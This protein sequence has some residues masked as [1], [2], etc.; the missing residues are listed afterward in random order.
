MMPSGSLSTP[1]PRYIELAT[2]LNYWQNGQWTA[3]KEKIEIAADG[4]SASATQGQHQAY[5]PSDIYQGAIGLVMPDGKVLQSQPIGLGYD[6]GSKAVMFAVLTN[7]TGQVLASGNQIIY[8]NAFTTCAVDLLYSYTLAG[9]E[10]DILIKEE[11]P[12]PESLGL[13][14][15]T[16]RLQ[17]YTEFFNA[18]QPAV[19]A[20]TLPEQAGIALADQTL[21]FGMM[22]MVP[23]RA[24]LIGN[25]LDSGTANAQ[26][27][28]Q[29]VQIGNRQILV[30][31][32]PVEAVAAALG[33]LPLPQITKINSSNSVRSQAAIKFR[34]PA[35][36]LAKFASKKPIMQASRSGHAMR[37]LLLDYQILNSSATN[38][39]FQGDSTYYISGSLILSGTNTFEGGA[40]LK[41]NTN[42]SLSVSAINWLA[43]PY[44][45]V[46]FTGKDDN[47]VG[48]TI[49]GS[50]GNPTNYYANPALSI[51][52]PGQTLTSFRIACARQGVSTP[53]SSSSFYNG[54]FV[55]CQ[56][57]LTASSATNLLRNILFANVKTNFNNLT[58]SRID[59][60]NGTFGNSFY[61]A[62]VNA[63]V[64]L[65]VTNSILASVTNLYSGSPV[66][67]TGGWNGFY[68]SPA[69]GGSQTTNTTFPFKTAGAGNYYLT[70]GC[71]FT[72]AGTAYIDAALWSGL[73]QKTT[74]SP[75][76]YSN[77][78]I[79][80]NTNFSPQAQRDTNSNPNLGY[81]YEPIDYLAD[82]CTITNAVLTVTNG[83][84][85]ASYNE[86]GVRLHNKSTIVSLGSPVNP[87]WFV[88]YSAVQE[89]PIS[90]K[91]SPGG[92][93]DVMP[94]YSSAMPSG[95]FRFTKFA[96][97]ANGGVHLYDFVGSS[98]SNLV[99]QD[100]E[101]WSGTNTLGGTNGAVITFKNNLFARSIIN[102]SGNGV[103]FFSNNLAWG[104]PAVSL[105]RTGT[106]AWYVFNNSF[107]S[108]SLTTTNLTNGNNAFLNCSGRI[109]PTNAN[110]V[111]SAAKL[112]YQAGPLGIFYQ[113][114]GSVLI[115]AGNTNADKIGFYHY[116]TQ[117]NQVKESNSIIDIGYHY[118]AAGANGLPLDSNG[119]GV[120]DY[121][122]DAN[123]NGIVD[124][125]EINW[126]LAIQI[127]PTNQTM[128][129][130]SNAT[131]VVTA[132]GVAP[133]SYQWYFNT[134][135]PL[136]N[137]TNAT[138]VLSN[139]Q[140]TNAGS[141]SVLVTN[142]TGS[143]TSSSA[144]LTVL[145][146]PSI[147]SQ[148]TNLAVRQGSNAIFSVTAT[149][150]VP[151]I[152]QWWFN[153]TNKIA[154]ATNATLTITN[155]QSTNTGNY[156]VVVTNSIG[157]VT[158]SN[159]SLI[160]LQPPTVTIT[161]PANN[162]VFAAGSGIN[163]GASA[164]AVSSIITQVQ[165]FQGATSLGVATNAPYSVIWSDEIVGTNIIT[166]QALDNY[167]QMAT[168][169]P[170]S[171]VIKAPVS[172]MVA[173]WR[174]E[175]TALD[176][177]GNSDGTLQG[178]VSYTN[179]VAGQT[180]SFDGNNSG[181]NV[182]NLT[183]L[184]SGNT[185]HSI[186]GWIKIQSLPPV[187]AWMLLLGAAGV[188]VHHWL[189][190][191]DGSAQLGVFGS[192]QANPTLPVGTWVHLAMTFNGQTLCCYTNGVL[193]SALAASFSFGNPLPLTLG[194][195]HL[196]EQG[197]N[198][199]MDEMSIYNRALS[200]NEIASIYNAGS[201]G[202]Q[203]PSVT[204][205]V[206]I[207][208][209]SNNAF[210]A[211]GSNVGL[212][213]SATDQ[214]GDV[215]QVQFFQGTN[216]LG[217]AT[218]SPYSMVWSNIAAG[219]YTLTAI[220]RD[221]LGLSATSAVVNLTAEY[222]PSVTL[223]NPTNNSVFVAGSSIYLSA[224][225]TDPDGT[226]SQVQFFQGTN[227]LG[228][229]TSAPYSMVWS[230]AASGTNTLTAMA[231]DNNG[232]S[233]TS[234]AVTILVDIPPVISITQPTNNT[235]YISSQTNVTVTAAVSDADGVVAWVQ[236]FQG[237]NS[238]GTVTNAPYSLT[239]SNVTAGS[240]SLTARAVDNN[241]FATVSAAVGFTVTPIS[242]VITNP[243]NNSVFTTNPAN[244][245]LNAV[246]SD[247]A[248][249]VTQVQYFS[250]TTSLGIATNP[251]YSFIWSNASNGNYALM[252]VAV[253]N[254]GFT[255][256]SSVVI[257]TV[258]D[259]LATNCLTLWLKG[260]AIT[261][262]TNNS[263]LATWPDSSG[264]SNN[265]TQNNSS[266]QPSYFTNVI[267]G[268]P[269]VRFYGGNSYLKLSNILYGT[270]G[271]EALIVL[272]TATNPF[273]KNDTL[274]RMGGEDPS[275]NL[276]YP[277]TS[278]QITEDFGC[279][280]SSANCK[281]LGVP[282]QP[283]TQFNVYEVSA[284]TGKWEAW[285]NGVLL[286]Q[287][288]NNVYGYYYDQYSSVWLGGDPVWSPG[289]YAGYFCGDIA[290]VLVF[291]RTLTI[292]ERGSVNSYINIK[293]GFVPQIPATPTNL[294]ATAI[295]P[296]QI[297]LTWSEQLNGGFT[298][299]GIERSTSS[300][301][302]F[303]LVAQL[304]N[305]LSYVDTNLAAGTTYY[306][307]VRAINVA[308]WTPPSNLAQATTPAA[309]ADVPLGSLL[310]WLK[311]DAGLVQSSS[312]APVEMWIDQSG[313]GNNATQPNGANQP[314]WVSG[315]MGDRPV[316]RFNGGS[317][318]LNLQ[319]IL[320]GTTGAEA[321]LVL[322]AATNQPSKN[323][324]LWRMGGEDTSVNL[325]YPNT[326]GQITEDFGCSGSLI[327][328]KNLGVPAQPLTQFNVYEVS[329][330]TGN[331]AAWLNGVLLYQTNSNVFA[332]YSSP[333]LGRDP[334]WSPSGYAGYFGGDIAEVLIFNRALTIS[335]R[336][337]VGAYL[338][339]KYQLAQ[340][341]SNN[342][343][344]G[345]PT[346][347]VASGLDSY[348]LNL[349]WRA[350]S[351]NDNSYHIERQSGTNGLFQ[352]IGVVPSYN[353]NFVDTTALPTNVYYY[354]V[355]SHNLFGDSG[356]SA[357]ISPPTV[358][359]TNWPTTII[360][361]ATNWI[362]AQAADVNG[363]VNSVQFFASKAL[364]GT[365]TLPAYAVN[366]SAPLEGTYSLVA[367]AA[368]N[369]G[370]TQFS[371]PV[372]VTAYL[373][374]NGNGLPDIIQVQG[375]NDPIN[376]W[377]PPAYDPN[378]HT[379]PVISLLIP[380][381]AIVV[382]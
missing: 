153:A 321:V 66:T 250:G 188:G 163:L 328:Y 181:M 294:V 239:W 272:K 178:G 199:L 261:G 200:S 285:L 26:M 180:F 319:N 147:T 378:D 370:N 253:D 351:T 11:P 73:Q 35:Q 170:I 98:Y 270:T 291:N 230:N 191:P 79:S 252:A 198:G 179:G 151:L 343:L 347:L 354:R 279:S 316:V 368:D 276:G 302:V 16:T 168:S 215:A 190:Q 352:E 222:A 231:Q 177:T 361:N 242:V 299:I 247:I 269:V 120:P 65:L 166:A 232:V 150:M 251:P 172:G 365:A 128:I 310:M 264:W 61:F 152:Y 374:S 169:S 348:Q 6:D 315:A 240:Y 154:T 303:Q 275:S 326:S 45:P 274:W 108:C 203:S 51:S 18:P 225:A 223:T 144:V 194:L 266:T 129:Q 49:S 72:N 331:W 157:N 283:L 246:A 161:N 102:A 77:V 349:H 39:T 363:T 338:L 12:T 164:S 235:V 41:Y 95:Q 281:N 107:D 207:T 243:L 329:A 304:A 162:A 214:I 23:G 8:A 284:R 80:I 15:A 224:S 334:V 289:G 196:G 44:R 318:Y 309:G 265:A 268:L 106:N 339:S 124:N 258:A 19:T 210:V 201:A 33:T 54:Q 244:I 24:F 335:E 295:S 110:D 156:T 364:V 238:I 30:E 38:Y 332:S 293:Y 173:W 4:N 371:I 307:Q 52:T 100:S 113:P 202:K 245:A 229:I 205:S 344:P 84:V 217:I 17:V 118:L 78:T 263:L 125:G 288:T 103:L 132:V 234:A 62:T 248:G 257:V 325:G 29:W 300:N 60:Q 377:I 311:S 212:G 48:E 34:L 119:D 143:I 87:N 167:G 379:A 67:F 359:L 380:T 139:V 271:A 308:Q 219:P 342:A 37:G 183:G 158:S 140:N 197:F 145:M 226:I 28:K 221:N 86:A 372:V 83:A 5:F 7:A 155:V 75:L 46:I 99:V 93:I 137:A 165:F 90:I 22:K 382:P 280:G 136:A 277:N 193:Q 228:I 70:N 111:V 112:S 50:T 175:G 192:V 356:Y 122:Q 85:I 366:W 376:P 255:A 104:V 40:V 358:S 297:S 249:T 115:N 63:G 290:E 176:T 32:V 13:N 131:F 218:N 20:T 148:P 262:L 126:G 14:P 206:T 141:Y 174:A 367:L 292:S 64:S 256:T 314:L 282:A 287:D 133:L 59:V 209:P 260:D 149:G 313:N 97:P 130:G 195:P 71:K 187:R 241:G 96:C 117:T 323:A 101:F 116:T 381:N 109:Y 340:H 182:D 69:F 324:A 254:N 353:T 355:K 94:S 286:Y 184:N 25:D 341:Q 259:V 213:A 89:Q 273:G 160:L 9:L 327:N 237:T 345:T 330:Q 42:A 134:N 227:N 171:L 27:G 135:T 373:V 189:L 55:N 159:A 142:F 322:K 369:L 362:F 68:K 127:Q 146:P 306:Y 121:L 267:N 204:M 81:H 76:V 350:T 53:S 58:S 43:A 185:P 320:S 91:G 105:N 114:A 375:G 216:S 301:G 233:T 312:N 208:N 138:L 278:G 236:F 298:Q 82:L 296:T 36:H 337:S 220:A 360:Q 3:S 305:S 346:N 92:G 47:S 10:Q 186:E 211:A 74:L 57:G 336:E 333:Q 31:E 357:I 1:I 2:G 88:R 317:S 21:D 123:G 56:N